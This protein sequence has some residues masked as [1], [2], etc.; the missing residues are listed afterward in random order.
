MRRKIG[1][2][3]PALDAARTLPS[4]ID[5]LRASLPGVHVVV[6]DDGSRD[7]TVA[8]AGRLA[9]DVV[10]HESNRGKGAALRSGFARVLDTGCEMLVTID[11]DGQHS[12]AVAPALVA[13]LD[14]ADLVIGAR[15]RRGT[16]MPL[17]RR[18][19]NTL[20]S[21]VVSALAGRRIG[22]SQSGFRAMRATVPATVRAE[23]DRFDFETDLLVRAA[24][25]GFRIAEVTVPTVYEQGRPSHFRNVRDT[26]YVLRA[27]A[28]LSANGWR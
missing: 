13:A 14:E 21:A 4:V 16:T 3:V 24:R 27:M 6:V 1:C 25:A 22:D 2:V 20:S 19:S 15:P 8:V 12:P 7:D 5:G 9:D 23:G 26:M 11:A 10:S 28:R 17:H 18:A